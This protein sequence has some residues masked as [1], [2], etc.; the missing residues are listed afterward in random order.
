MGKK[1][2]KYNRPKVFDIKT[3]ALWKIEQDSHY[4]YI[5]I[6]PKCNRFEF[7]IAIDRTSFRPE[8]TCIYRDNEGTGCVLYR[9]EPSD[10]VKAFWNDLLSEYF[11]RTSGN[12]DLMR[13][14]I[15]D[16]FDFNWEGK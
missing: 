4:K 6:S 5:C 11:Q 1:V 2:I 7:S 14:R 9:A 13:D 16:E 15:L 8:F 3:Y 12:Q 10:H